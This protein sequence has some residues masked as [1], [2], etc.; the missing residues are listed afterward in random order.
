MKCPVC[1]TNEARLESG[2]LLICLDCETRM[3]DDVV[4]LRLSKTNLEHIG[5]PPQYHDA[6]IQEV[7]G[8]NYVYGNPGTGKTTYVVGIAKF[9]MSI[10]ASVQF[11]NVMEVLAELRS[12]VFK[13]VAEYDFLYKYLVA[14]VLV[15]DDVGVRKN[16]EWHEQTLYLILNHRLNHG[17]VTVVTGNTNLDGMVDKLGER[18]VSRLERMCNLVC[19]N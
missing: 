17:L 11:M 8:S 16:S 1:H 13:N 19:L 3:N 10:G 9:Y 4:Q 14:D 2:I 7:R 6:P 5:I 15:M 18:C 12:L